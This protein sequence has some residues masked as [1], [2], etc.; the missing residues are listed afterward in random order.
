MAKGFAEQSGGALGIESAPGRGT[1]VSLWLPLARAEHA[2]E[3][4]EHVAAG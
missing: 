1:R 2:A 3:P 4:A